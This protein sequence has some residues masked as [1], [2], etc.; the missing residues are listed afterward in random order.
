ME[1]HLIE[2][3]DD[4]AHHLIVLLLGCEEQSMS[5]NSMVPALKILQSFNLMYQSVFLYTSV[6]TLGVDG[7]VSCQDPETS[8]RQ[9]RLEEDHQ[10]I[11]GAPTAP[12]RLRGEEDIYN[13]SYQCIYNI[14]ISNQIFQ[15]YISVYL[16]YFNTAYQI[17]QC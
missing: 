9:R 14:S 16:Q 6:F 11:C 8:R 17:F 10:N 3:V 1:N 15:Y 5:V 12:Q 7:A 13:I 4:L 2:H